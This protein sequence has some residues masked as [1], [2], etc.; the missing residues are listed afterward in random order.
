MK[1]HLFRKKPVTDT[2]NGLKRVLGFYDLTFLGIAAIVGAGI[3]STVGRASFEG[4]PAISLLFIFTAIACGL[5]ALC[6]AQFASNIPDGGSAYTYTYVSLGELPAWI[7]GWDLVMEYAIGNIAVAISWSDYLTSLLRA[8]QINF[9]YWLSTDWLSAFKQS[10]QEG[11]LA[12]ETAPEIA[13]LKIVFD[14]PALLITLFITILLYVG[15]KESKKANNIMVIVKL[16]VL[17]LVIVCGAFYVKVENWT[18]FAPNG[19]VGVLKGVSAVFF[20]YIG[21]DAISTVAEESKNPKKDLPRAMIASLLV[22]TLVY[23]VLSLVMTGMVS[24]QKLDVGDPIA[25]V[26]YENGLPVFASFLALSAVVMMASVFLVFQLG[27]P[28]IWMS[29]SRDG[30]LPK[31]FSTIHPKFKTPAF[32][33]VV[34]GIIVAIPCLFMNLT[35]VTDLTSIGTLFAFLMVCLG[36]WLKNPESKGFKVPFINGKFLMPIISIAFLVGTNQLLDNRYLNAISNPIEGDHFI[37]I[38]FILGILIV[39]AITYS[40]NLSLLPALGIMVNLFLLSELGITNWS[41]FLIWL[42]I[43][44]VI[45]FVYG[46]KKSNLANA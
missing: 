12:W 45:Y 22:C 25:F 44:L 6:Y 19:F 24:Y 18:P 41:R 42:A 33:T 2:D 31:S 21:F 11:R 1:T 10:G 29:M 35:E 43:G 39:S 36:I 13:G 3:F 32:S 27:Q 17:I 37:H 14:F 15:I 46:V 8:N 16:L 40:K 30:L 26:F 28:R 7:I 34:S 4:G 20:A 23:V 38:S 9:P 5:S